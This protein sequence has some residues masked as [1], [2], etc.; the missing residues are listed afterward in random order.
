MD[1]EKKDIVTVNLKYGSSVK[2][3]KVLAFAQ[4]CAKALYVTK[5]DMKLESISVEVARLIG[6]KKVSNDL[7]LNGLDYL[8]EIN[9]ITKRDNSWQLKNE[10]R[11]EVSRNIDSSRHQ[12]KGV[13][14][15]HFPEVDNPKLLKA[16]FTEASAHFFGHYG[17]EWVSAISKNIKSQSYFRNNTIDELLLPSINTCGFNKIQQQLIKGFIAFLSSD[18]N[19]DQQY[20]MLISQAMF[21]AR[22]VAADV[23]IDPITLEELRDSTFVLDT[24][25]LLPI[26]L[27]NG[28]RAK[29][30]NSLEGALQI[31][32][33]N[34]IYTNST[35]EE[36]GRVVTGK[37]GEILHLIDVFPGEVIEDVSDDFIATAKTRKCRTREDYER[38]FQSLV[39]IPASLP[40]GLGINLE[41]NNE[42]QSQIEAAEKDDKLKKQ[43]RKDSIKLRAKWR[44]PKSESA[45]NH[46]AALFHVSEFIK[47]ESKCWILSSDRSLQRLAIKQASPHEIPVVLS[48][49]ALIEI[50][51]VNNAGPELD[52]TDF[53][54]L[55]ANIILNECIPPINTYLIQDLTLLH[56]INEKAAELPPDDIK[57]I[58]GEIIRARIDGKKLRDT[59]LELKVNRMYQESVINVK[60]S[61]KETREKYKLVQEDIKKEKEK[62]ES[63]EKLL[64]DLKTKQLKN[65]A[66]GL[67]VWRLFVKSVVAILISCLAVVIFLTFFD[68]ENKKEIIGYALGVLTFILAAWKQIP[69]AFL[70]YKKSCKEAPRNAKRSLDA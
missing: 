39:D 51:S 29:A 15:R 44:G 53:A 70:E 34:L 66:L 67:L 26:A 56:K 2:P 54:P 52:A 16:W 14:K 1:I 4:L 61:L 11:K 46:D 31:L 30:I 37:R 57:G 33:S 20:L 64:I 38:F 8:E 63:R 5:T 40:N 65:K 49:S 21:S 24:N 17:D 50:L 45:L 47:K 25:V 7:I 35:K 12:V 55:L 32:N 68:R 27:E 48:L 36:Y 43:L 28:K 59:S 9:E 3:L 6:V 62:T 41:D 10:A 22:L 19:A 60:R 69:R 18:D 13:L 58:V 23:G 42:I